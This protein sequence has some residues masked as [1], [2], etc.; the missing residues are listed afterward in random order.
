MMTTALV[1]ES[2]LSQGAVAGGMGQHWPVPPESLAPFLYGVEREW[3]RRHLIST[4]KPQRKADLPFLRPCMD[5]LTSPEAEKAVRR[6]GRQYG[7]SALDAEDLL[8]TATLRIWRYLEARQDLQIDN[9]AGFCYR[10]VQ[11]MIIDIMRGAIATAA[12]DE[13]LVPDTDWYAKAGIAPVDPSDE[14][15]ERVENHDG[16]DTVRAHLEASGADTRDVSA[17]LTYITLI[18]HTDIDCDDLPQPRAGAKP[19]HALWWPCL[20]L[21]THDGTLFPKYDS[22]SAAQRKRLQRARERAEDVL[23]SAFESMGGGQ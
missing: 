14:H 15:E 21:A 17:A 18:G 23:R 16:I 19:E 20:W 1:S 22:G 6:L 2:A 11:R 5:W 13:K 8:G 7:L 4:K 9:V 3:T 10:V 12:V